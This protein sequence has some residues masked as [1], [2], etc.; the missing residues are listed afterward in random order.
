MKGKLLCALLSNVKDI[1]YVHGNFWLQTKQG[2][3]SL[4]KSKKYII[5]TI[6]IRKGTW[7][8]KAIIREQSKYINEYDYELLYLDKEYEVDEEDY[9]KIYQEYNRLKN[10]AIEK[11]LD[12]L[13]NNQ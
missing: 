2:W 8:T 3:I 9:I 1:D 11:E 13:C 4:C 5:E 12:E 10:E 7:F 6:I